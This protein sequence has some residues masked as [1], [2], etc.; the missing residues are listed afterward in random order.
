MP[1]YVLASAVAV[2]RIQLDKH[3]LSDVV[4]GAALGYIVGRTVV[5][6]N[7]APLDK[8]GGVVVSVTPLLGRQTR[9]LM[10]A[11]VF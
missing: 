10:V 5:R 6:V 7:S 11:V 2:S 1:A 4:A 9:G 8:R 3:Y